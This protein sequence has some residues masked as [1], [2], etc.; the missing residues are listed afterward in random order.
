MKKRGIIVISGLVASGKSTISSILSERLNAEVISSDITRKKMAGIDPF[1]HIKCG[2]Q[3]DIYSP[4]FTCKVYEKLIETAI[5]KAKKGKYVIIDATF[6]KKKF[7]DKLKE[8]AEGENIPLFFFFLATPEKTIIER[9]KRR[10]IEKTV[11]DA[12]INVYLNMKKNYDYPQKDERIVI[13]KGD[14]KAENIVET[15]LNTIKEGEDGF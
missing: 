10:S 12:D 2:Y 1:S 7:R 11:S 9:L 3:K 14:E 8:A 4:S 6:S 13:L 15:I 5:D